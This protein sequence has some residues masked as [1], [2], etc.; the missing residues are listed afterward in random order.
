MTTENT[1]NNSSSIESRLDSAFKDDTPISNASDSWDDEP[2]PEK[3]EKKEVADKFDRFEDEGPAPE[4]KKKEEAKEEP[5]KETKAERQRRLERLKIDG[6]EEVVDV[7]QVLRDYAKYKSADAEKRQVAEARKQLEA[8]YQQFQ[9]DPVAVL[10]QKNLPINKRQ[11]AEQWLKESIEAEM[12]DPRDIELEEK[13]DKL[14]KYEEAILAHKKAQAEQES[15]RRVE[16]RRTELSETFGKAMAASVLSKDPAES[17][18]V[19]RE[20][21]MY[22]RIARQNGE[23]MPSAEELAAHVENSRLKQYHSVAQTLDGDDLI[24]FL[25]E[26]IVK[27][28]RQ[29]DLAR[30]RAKQGLSDQ[31]P[32]HKSE[33]WGDDGE[34]PTKSNKREFI[35]PVTARELARKRLGL[36]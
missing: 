13:T 30:L 8:F 29:A 9:R 11:L 23:E 6:K 15:T 2:A 3:E 32:V 24:S 16:T 28:I 5:R 36:K 19:L 14:R 35:D 26:S 1:T 22:A 12:K 10:N 18:A 33:T 34:K 17:A 27:K 7:D 21:A 25:G 4:E 31:A 20:M